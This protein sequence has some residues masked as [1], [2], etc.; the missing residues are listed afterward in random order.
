MAT[1]CSKTLNCINLF[2]YFLLVSPPLKSVPIPRMRTK[3]TA[4]NN[5]IDNN[6]TNIP[7]IINVLQGV[8]KIKNLDLYFDAPETLAKKFGLRGIPTSILFNKEGLEF[9]RIIGSIDFEDQKFID[10]LIKYN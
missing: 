9:A 8:L 2:E 10:W 3:P 1:N 4:S 5:A 6:F 7:E